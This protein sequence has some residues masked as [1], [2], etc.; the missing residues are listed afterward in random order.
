M[1]DETPRK[2]L[3]ITRK[4]ASTTTESP[5]KAITRT[6]KRIITRDQLPAANLPKPKPPKPKAPPKG[7]GRARKP[8]KPKAPPK[9][10]PSDL[11]ARELN[12]S[13]NAFPVWREHQPLALGIERQIFQ[14]I[15]ALHLS[16]SKRVVNKLLHYQTHNRRYLLNIKRGG[17]RFNLDGTDGGAIIQPE[18]EHAARQLEAIPKT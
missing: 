5:P 13:L 18:Q 6:G 12:D 10:P 9:T 14:H 4:A 8:P 3:T 17:V 11:R 7:K 16:A 2:T 1:N 15:A